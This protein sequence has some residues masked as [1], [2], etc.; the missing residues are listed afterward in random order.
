MENYYTVFDMTPEDEGSLGY[1]QIGIGEKI[2]SKSF[3]YEQGAYVNVFD[4]DSIIKYD[5]FGNP[6]YPTTT[7]SSDAD[8]NQK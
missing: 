3:E 6:I 1:I 8:N 2:K 7:D 4:D 5:K